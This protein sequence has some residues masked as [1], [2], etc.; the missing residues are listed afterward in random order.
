MGLLTALHGELLNVAIEGGL[1]L[2][3]SAAGS[4]RSP[5]HFPP[6]LLGFLWAGSR[7]PLLEQDSE[8][9]DD[10]TRH[11]GRDQPHRLPQIVHR[12]VRCEHLI[13]LD[14]SSG[15][16][17]ADKHADAVSDQC[18]ALAR[19]VPGAVLLT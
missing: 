4:C 17:G 19:I 6:S 18:K 16:L 5:F 7:R 8:K 12:A 11:S 14:D 3:L 2:D 1:G 10:C 13:M 9:Y 15:D